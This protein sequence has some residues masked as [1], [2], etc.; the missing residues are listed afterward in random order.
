[1]VELKVIDL[2][3]DG[4][5]GDGVAEHQRLFELP[6]FIRGRELIEFLAAEVTLAVVELGRSYFLKRDL[7][8]AELA[9]Q[10]GIGRIVAD[11]VVTGKGFLRIE[12]AAAQVVD[13]EQRLAA[14]VGGQRV[15]RILRA[16][17]TLHIGHRARAGI[18]GRA[19]RRS[20]GGIAHR[21]Q[22]HQA[23]RV[24]GEQRHVGADGGVGGGAQLRLVIDAIEAHAAGKVDER[25]LLIQ[26]AEH[27][28]GGLN[29]GK[30]AVGVEDVEFA[31]VLAE[32]GESVRSH[33][34]AVGF[35][36][37]LAFAN[38]QFLDGLLQQVAVG[39]EV[40]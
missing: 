15:H 29:G 26:I 3:G 11:D 33:V 39:R 37:S 28:R 2:H 14:R 8:A 1:M 5:V 23:P 40:L 13:I 32:G 25:L 19:A 35:L 36:E 27:L 7:H 16:L 24:D 34:V 9:I 6:F 22:R 20:V 4:Q 30:L 38:D 10:C 18:H 21:R 17:Q 31:I 12:D